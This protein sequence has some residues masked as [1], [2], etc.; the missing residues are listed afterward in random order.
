M[1]EE[2]DPGR[3]HGRG[4]GRV[5]PFWCHCRE[6][7]VSCNPPS[8]SGSHRLAG[9]R[10]GIRTQ[11]QELTR[12][13][14][15]RPLAGS[16]ARAEG[17]KARHQ[18]LQL[19][20][21]ATGLR[22]SL[23]GRCGPTSACREASCGHPVEAPERLCRAQAAEAGRGGGSCRHSSQA[24]LPTA[25]PMESAQK[26]PFPGAPGSAALA[27][28]LLGCPRTFHLFTVFSP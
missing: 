15:L 24:F 26:S 17:L 23:G 25:P 21:G 13:A 12:W 20:L 2:G 14:G 6:G 10:T 3:F 5:P 4:G 11:T 1:G 27:A 18:G 19:D 22:C 28:L 8:P 9:Q 7:P 16:L